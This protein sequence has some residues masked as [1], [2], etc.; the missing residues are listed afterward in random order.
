[1]H[2]ISRMMAPQT[3][4]VWTVALGSIVDPDV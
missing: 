1:L 4:H 3:Q 2:L